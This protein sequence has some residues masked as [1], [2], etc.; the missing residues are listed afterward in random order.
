ISWRIG[1]VLALSFL[2]CNDGLVKSAKL[3]ESIPQPGKRMLEQRINRA[4]AHSVLKASD[5]LLHQP[6]NSVDLAPAAP[7]GQRIWIKRNRLVS[8][9][10][11]AFADHE[12]PDCCSP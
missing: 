4:H 11:F 8:H 10:G 12:R 5:R 1:G 6:C 9:L 2:R 7:C 3:N